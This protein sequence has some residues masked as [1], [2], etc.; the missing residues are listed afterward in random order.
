MHFA[1]ALL[2]LTLGQ[3]TCLNV[4]LNVNG[5]YQKKVNACEVFIKCHNWYMSKVSKGEKEGGGKLLPK[6]IWLNMYFIILVWVL[7]QILNSQIGVTII[8]YHFFPTFL[9]GSLTFQL[10]SSQ[11]VVLYGTDSN[12]SDSW[13]RRSSWL[14]HVSSLDPTWKIEPWTAHSTVYQDAE[15]CGLPCSYM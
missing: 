10:F 8:H 3:Q 9:I 12:C 6:I 4:A 5:A 15:L 11:A 14:S 2:N 1:Q 13:F 7:Y